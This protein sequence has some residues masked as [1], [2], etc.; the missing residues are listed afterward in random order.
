MLLIMCLSLLSVVL[1]EKLPCKLFELRFTKRQ[2]RNWERD[3]SVH[4]EYITGDFYLT[5]VFFFD[6][7]ARKGPPKDPIVLSDM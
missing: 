1:L 7:H 6:D 5:T 4:L 2:S 3:P